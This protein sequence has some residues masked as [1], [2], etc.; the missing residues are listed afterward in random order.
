MWLYD[1]SDLLVLDKIV[2][3][4]VIDSYSKSISVVQLKVSIS[5]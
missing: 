3:Y 5:H 4:S 2:I 1:S